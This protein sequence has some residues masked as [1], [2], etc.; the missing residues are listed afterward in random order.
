M[1]NTTWQ[2]AQAWEKE[3]WEK[4]QNTLGE[5]LKQM[6]YADRMGLT[7]SPNEKTPYRFDMDG[8]SVL[9]IG[10]GPSSLLLKCVNAQGKVIDPI[11]FPPWVYQR[12]KAVGIRYSIQKAEDLDGNE[13]FDECW[14]YNVLQ[15]TENPARIIR[16]ARTAAKLIRIFEWIDMRPCP[17]HP[18]ILTREKLDEWLDG[19]GKVEDKIAGIAE[20]DCLGKGYYGIFPTG[21]KRK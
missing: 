18:Q 4:C 15:H 12:Y 9:D 20:V 21:L 2:S 8:K 11:K 3:W 19:E 1:A 6:V 13:S 7:R 16:N 10:G 17:G 5:E 14:I